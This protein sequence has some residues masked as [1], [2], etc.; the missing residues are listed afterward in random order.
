MAIEFIKINGEHPLLD[1]QELEA[2]FHRVFGA[3][4]HDAKIF[5][6]NRFPIQVTPEVDLDYILV[7]A[8]PEGDGNF[9]QFKKGKQKPK[10]KIYLHNLVV[11]VLHSNLYT[12]SE[13]SKEGEDLLVDGECLD[14]SKEMTSLQYGLSTYFSNRCGFDATVYVHPLYYIK[15]QNT[16]VGESFIC[17]SEFDFHAVYRWLNESKKTILTSYQK[18]KKSD[19]YEGVAKDLS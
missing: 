16:L 12:E 9:I 10:R 4:C 17:R 13:I 18:W 19:G 7:I 11:P 3:T 15:N 8:L 6:F 5:I 2:S 1:Y 14:I